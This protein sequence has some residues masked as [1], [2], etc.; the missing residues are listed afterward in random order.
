M[1]L[2]P[3]NLRKIYSEGF[4]MGEAHNPQDFHT[5]TLAFL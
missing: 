1:A 3:E 4:T 2:I 5:D